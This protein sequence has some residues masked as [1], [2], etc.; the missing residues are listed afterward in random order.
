MA[1]SI[2]NALLLELCNVLERVDRYSLNVTIHIFTGKKDKFTQEISYTPVEVFGLL[3]NPTE[4]T[5]STK[6]TSP[7]WFLIYETKSANIAIA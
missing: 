6:N 4:V 2:V 1:S 7:V 5:S 3:K